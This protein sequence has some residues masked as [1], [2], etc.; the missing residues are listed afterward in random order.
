MS[1]IAAHI[2]NNTYI[3]LKRILAVGVLFPLDFCV[4]VHRRI[5]S[6]RCGI[7]AIPGDCSASRTLYDVHESSSSIDYTTIKVFGRF[8]GDLGFFFKLPR[9][10]FDART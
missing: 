1:V 7:V 3:F 8:L 6:I 9:N 2:E 4:N 5:C 10:H